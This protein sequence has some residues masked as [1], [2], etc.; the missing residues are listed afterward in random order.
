MK[1]AKFHFAK[2]AS[3]QS[4]HHRWQAAS[5][6]LLMYNERLCER[7]YEKEQSRGIKNSKTEM[8]MSLAIV[9]MHKVGLCSRAKRE[10]SIPAKLHP[11][12]SKEDREEDFRAR[13]ARSNEEL[14]ECLIRMA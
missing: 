12:A 3:R 7:L 14:V 1:T 10:A 13:V 8:E 9:I 4:L 11:N 6:S 5:E 2:F